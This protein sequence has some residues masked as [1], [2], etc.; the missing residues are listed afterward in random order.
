MEKVY[1]FAAAG[2][3]NF[4]GL[5]RSK[6]HLALQAVDVF[7]GLLAAQVMAGL[8]RMVESA[9]QS[10]QRAEMLYGLTQSD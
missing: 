4:G 10:K 5:R 9:A 1:S 6:F 8:L 7:F 2:A 3:E